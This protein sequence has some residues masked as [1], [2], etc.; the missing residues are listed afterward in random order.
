MIKCVIWDLDNTLLAGTYLESPDQRL[1]ADP[2]A[3]RALAELAGRGILHAIASRNPPE[4]A[5]C[6]ATLTGHAF[7]AARLGWG[8]KSAAVAGILGELGLSA[9]EAAFV[10]DDP[11]ER[12][13]VGRALPE[14]LVLAPEDLAEA[15]GWP[16]FSPPVIT[17]E[18]RRRG[19]MYA[20]RRVR[21]EEAAAFGGSAD[22]FLR[23]CR[24]EVQIAEATEADLPRLH[25]LS[26]R[27][28]QFNSVGVPVGAEIFARLA[29]GPQ[30]PS[31][32][33]T[34]RLSDKFGDDGLVG[35]CVIT[36]SGGTWHVP[37]LMMSCRAL[38]RGVIG[39]LLAWIRRAASLAD[40][41]EVVVTCVITDRNVPLRIALTGA[42]FRADMAAKITLPDWAQSGEH[43]RVAAYHAAPGQ[44]ELPHWVVEVP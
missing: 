26:F 39:A 2:D 40:A 32:V 17:P 5:A 30:G 1:C 20:S 27:T 33:V 35:G 31:R 13:E 25:E 44:P 9:G 19:D 16:E 11:L 24:T 22:E 14:V 18:A 15:I 43:A 41:S 29:G 21:Q 4:A 28:H 8:K 7:A 3:A 12:G 10:D 23:Y 6:A 42:G 36:V 37:L 34:V 38:G